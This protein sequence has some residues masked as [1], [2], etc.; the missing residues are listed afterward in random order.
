MQ[1]RQA[2][3][4]KEAIAYLKQAVE[5]EPGNAIYQKELADLI[6]SQVGKFAAQGTAALQSTSPPTLASINRARD[7]L[8]LAR[9]IAPDSPAAKRSCRKN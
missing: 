7:Q 9:E 1:L 2:G 5:N 4:Y 6:D 8:L 3:K